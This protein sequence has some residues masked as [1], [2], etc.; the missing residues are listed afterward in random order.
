ML[1]YVSGQPFQIEWPEEV[2]A[3]L[4]D[5]RQREAQAREDRL[6]IMRE[7]GRRF[8]FMADNLEDLRSSGGKPFI[9]EESRI[10]GMPTMAYEEGKDDFLAESAYL[11]AGSH[12]G[13][14]FCGWVRGVPEETPYD[15]IGVLSGSAGTRFTCPVCNAQI[16]E[17]QEIVS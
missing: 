13:E 2:Q 16:G 6:R 5:A 3:K 10:R 14:P 7:E 4:K 1:R 15:D 9:R 11:C 8:G 17:H 12:T